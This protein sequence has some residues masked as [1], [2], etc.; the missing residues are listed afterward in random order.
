MALKVI[1]K[2]FCLTFCVLQ[3][4]SVVKQN[5]PCIYRWA[6][7]HSKAQWWK[8]SPALLPCLT[9][10]RVR[11]SSMA[12]LAELPLG[13]VDWSHLTGAGRAVWRLQHS[14]AHVPALWWAG[15]DGELPSP[16]SFPQSQAFS[17]RCLQQGSQA[18]TWQIRAPRATARLPVFKAGCRMSSMTLPFSF[19]QVVADPR[20]LKGSGNRLGLLM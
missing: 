13:G 4:K 15:W 10:F 11:K 5:C 17:L 16:L 2:I 3:T 20:R 19:G 7:G 12:R 18:S 14:C 9:I 1:L 8:A 6:P